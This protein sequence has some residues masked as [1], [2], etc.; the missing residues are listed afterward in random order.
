[1]LKFEL[2]AESIMTDR[3]AYILLNMMEKIGPITVRELVDHLGSVSA[4]FTA[5]GHDLAGARGTGRETVD[6]IVRQRDE[7]DVAHEIAGADSLGARIITP[8]DPEYPAV[9]NQIHDPPLALYVQGEFETRDQHAFAVVGTRRPSHYGRDTAERLA[10]QLSMAGYVVVSG[11]AEGIDTVAHRGALKAQGR[12]L[13]VLGGGLDHVY[14]ASNRGLAKEIADHGVVMTELP[15]GRR[16]DRTTF[17]MRNRI[18]SGLS[19]GVVVVEAGPR[20]G[21]LITVR[22]ALEQGRSVFAVPG[23]I[24]SLRSQGCNELIR[25]GATLVTSADDILEDFEYLFAQPDRRCSEDA[26]PR[27]ELSDDES[28]LVS[29]LDQ[30][31]SDVDSIIRATGLNP[32]NVSSTLLSL[33]MKN[34][35]R[36]LPGRTVELVRAAVAGSR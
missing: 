34:V 28:A 13:A 1:M 6:A 30:G 20:S 10:Y 22:Q 21:A 31:E 17:P 19:A 23:R 2:Y 14:P 5:R 29:A 8:V 9:L 33:E 7:L 4:I 25:G 16:P 32:A 3:E 12:T 18:V 24:D 36:M 35:V 11:M 26:M 15:L 27:I